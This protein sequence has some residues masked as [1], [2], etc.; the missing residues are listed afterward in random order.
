MSRGWTDL[1]KKMTE[2]AFS[3]LIAMV[4]EEKKKQK[5]HGLAIVTVM[6]GSK[7]VINNVRNLK[8]VDILFHGGE[9][10]FLTV[11]GKGSK[12]MRV[13]AEWQPKVE[14]VEGSMADEQRY[15]RILATRGL[16]SQ[17]ATTVTLPLRCSSESELRYTGDQHS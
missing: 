8:Y 7:R 16:F 4:E 3:L 5:A 9:N 11:E 13:E 12:G 6:A 15:H 2:M 1:E 17:E 14:S 10:L